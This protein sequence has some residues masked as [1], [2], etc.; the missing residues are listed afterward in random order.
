MTMKTSKL[1]A[2]SSALAVSAVVAAVAL[3]SAYK[4]D[5]QYE[6]NRD[7]PT[8][9]ADTISTMSCYLSKLKVEEIL[10][11]STTSTPEPYAAWLDVEACKSAGNVANDG[12]TITPPTYDRLWVQP[13]LVNGVIQVK[14]WGVT[15]QGADARNVHM[16]AAIRQGATAA[17]PYGDWDVDW[18]VERI[19]TSVQHASYPCFKKGHIRVSPANYELYYDYNGSA[20]QPYTIRSSGMVSPDMG[21]GN[22]RFVELRNNNV[23]LTTS[24][25]FAFTSG[26]L[27]DVTNG[28]ATCKNP[29][30]TAEGV[31][32]SVWEAWL[33]D[34]DTGNKL[35]VNGGFPVQNVT[36]KESGW[37]GFDGVRLK[38]TE[39]V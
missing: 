28:V 33:Y 37:A 13:S 25:H 2:I 16:A 23:A 38:G 3:S 14:L 5:R 1:I 18:C 35:S 36:T 12:G 21:S 24:G 11:A 7:S 19:S 26:A 32:S 8:I 29:S 20:S 15:G 22:G 39:P 30:R 17:P 27:S 9:A 34:K 31:L 4:S 6:V 10:A